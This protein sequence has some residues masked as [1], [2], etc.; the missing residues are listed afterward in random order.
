M[1]GDRKAHTLGHEDMLWHIYRHAFARP[2]IEQ[3]IRL[4]WV[5]DFVSLVEKYVKEI[6]WGRLKQ[7]YPQV[8]RVMPL[9]HWLSPL[10]DRVLEHL[11]MDLGHPP[12]GVGLSFQGW[13]TSS[14]AA[15]RA[16]GF[17]RILT[18]TFWPPVWWT[19]LYY[20]RDGRGLSWWW[21][22]LAGHPLHIAGWLVRYTKQRKRRRGRS[23]T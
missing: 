17:R 1:V 20:G 9:F 7:T 4:I 19:R 11:N 14:L 10:S 18:D 21:T 12:E 23:R 2:L 8:W 5:A 13:P 22:R 15:Q 6:D 3:P 16:K